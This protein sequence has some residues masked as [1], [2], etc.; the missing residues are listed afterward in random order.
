MN[1]P[2][3]GKT[4]SGKRHVRRKTEL[5]NVENT[6]FQEDS[7]RKKVLRKSNSK[8]EYKMNQSRKAKSIKFQ[9]RKTESRKAKSRKAKFK[10]ANSEVM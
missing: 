2:R 9:F 10:K 8:T 5:S 1:S 4:E 6:E 3:S 7:D